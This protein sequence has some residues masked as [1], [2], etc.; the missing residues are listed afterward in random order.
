MTPLTS[1][2][3]LT[4]AFAVALAVVSVYR[5][6]LEIHPTAFEAGELH[7]VQ[8]TAQALLVATLTSL[9]LTALIYFCGAS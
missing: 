9:G 8:R 4:A 2:T 7:S 6:Y 1:S 5:V 3:L